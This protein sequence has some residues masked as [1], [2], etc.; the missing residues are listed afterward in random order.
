MIKIGEEYKRNLQEQVEKNKTD[1]KDL[2]NISNLLGIKVLGVIPYIYQLPQE[3]DYTGEYG[4]AYLVG[5]ELPYDLYVWTRS[6]EEIDH[7]HWFLIGSLEGIVGPQ[8]IQGLPGEKGERGPQ[9]ERGERGPAGQTGIQ[10]PQGERGERGATG[11]QGL[12]GDKGDKGDSFIIKNILASTDLLP[13]PTEDIREQAY[14]VGTSMPYLC[15]VIVEGATGLE[16]TAIG[17]LGVDLSNYYQKNEVNNMLSNKADINGTYDD[18]S[19][20]YATDCYNSH[21]SDLS[22]EANVIQINNYQSDPVRYNSLQYAFIRFTNDRQPKLYLNYD[23]NLYSKLYI[24]T[25]VTDDLHCN[26]LKIGGSNISDLYQEKGT[27]V[28]TNSEAVLDSVAI[29]EFINDTS[30][31]NF[32]TVRNVTPYKLRFITKANTKSV[33]GITDAENAINASNN[34]IS[35]LE[36]FKT[37]QESINTAVDTYLTNISN[38]VNSTGQ[39]VSNISTITIPL[40]NNRL[41]ALEDGLGDSITETQFNTGLSAKLDKTGGSLASGWLYAPRGATQEEDEDAFVINKSIQGFA[42]ENTNTTFS[43]ITIS[44]ITTNTTPTY[45]ATIDDNKKLTRT[46][47]AYMKSKLGIT[48]LEND[49]QAKLVS[50]TNIKRINGNS[51]LG[52]GD[53]T[54]DTTEIPVVAFTASLLINNNGYNLGGSGDEF[55]AEVV[56]MS[57]V[58]QGQHCVQIRKYS[59]TGTSYRRKITQ[60][61]AKYFLLKLTGSKFLP[62]YQQDTPRYTYVCES[63]NGNIYKAQFSEQYGLLFYSLAK[64]PFT[65]PQTPSGGMFTPSS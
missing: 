59:P 32:V 54:I 37:N 21:G 25:A 29:N 7:S 11:L 41:D 22:R 65:A 18:M 10:G 53:L 44:G 33:L 8:G 58:P 38:T 50:G 31:S 42:K 19:V 28:E 64:I 49:K 30:G 39:N 56:N 60:E 20:G 16:W 3:N 47:T 9:G 36:S 46:S 55:Y 61:E 1:I 13:S 57:N 51:I 45:Y 63:Q 17:F 48:A 62:T 4:D 34:R 43:G 5:E 40:I 15:Y 26:S 27:Y 35:Q 52:S 24:D 12:K 14:L 6:N 23:N 2:K